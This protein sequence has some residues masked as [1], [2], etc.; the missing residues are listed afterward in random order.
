M[1]GAGAQLRDVVL[2]RVPCS[3]VYT[4]EYQDYLRLMSALNSKATSPE[5]SFALFLKYQFEGRQVE[6][7]C[8]VC[9][10]VNRWDD[11]LETV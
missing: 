4:S 3:C 7:V 2:A 9:S 1:R 5:E 11:I 10:A 8:D 6:Q